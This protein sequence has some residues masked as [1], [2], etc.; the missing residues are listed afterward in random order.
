MISGSASGKGKQHLEYISEFL[1]SSKPAWFHFISIS[2]YSKKVCSAVVNT[3]T[4]VVYLFDEESQWEKQVRHVIKQEFC[5]S[6]IAGSE[7]G[8]SQI[9]DKHGIL[10]VLPAPVLLC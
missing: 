3:A 6:I 2:N 10:N 7:K 5:N 8:H 9:L 4:L 1:S